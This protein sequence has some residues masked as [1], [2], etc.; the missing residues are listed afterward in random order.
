MGRAGAGVRTGCSVPGT[1]AAEPRS[2]KAGARDGPAAEEATVTAR[3]E[4]WPEDQPQGW[5][6]RGGAGQVETGVCGAGWS[7]PNPSHGPGSHPPL[8]PGS[9]QTSLDP[10]GW[11]PGRFRDPRPSAVVCPF[12]SAPTYSPGLS[13]EAPEACWRGVGEERRKWGPGTEKSCRE[14]WGKDG[15]GWA[16]GP[17]T[18]R[19]CCFIHVVRKRS[20]GPSRPGQARPSS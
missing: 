12:D 15:W 7:P 18:L 16:Q 20:L 13:N 2:A 9:I 10:V 1:G 5:A 19:N 6:G 8:P 17:D 4:G 3:G 14:T 11:R